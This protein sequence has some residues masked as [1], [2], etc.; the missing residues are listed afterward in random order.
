MNILNSNLAIGSKIQK[1]VI[2]ND[3]AILI[4]DVCPVEIIRE[5]PKE[6]YSYLLILVLFLLAKSEWLNSVCLLK[7][8]PLN[9]IEGCKKILS[10]Y[11]KECIASS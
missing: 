4:T 10:S 3:S 5:V 8:I 2:L 11:K 7:I 6:L 9:Y 1:K